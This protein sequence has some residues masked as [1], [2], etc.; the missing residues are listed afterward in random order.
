MDALNRPNASAHPGSGS[1]RTT[2]ATASTATTVRGL[3]RSA[4]RR[5]QPGRPW[6][7]GA[8]WD[9]EGVNFA[10]F[11]GAATQVELC[12]FDESGMHE[13][14]RLP[15]PARDQDIW[16][17]Y[18]PKAGPG[19]V[20]GFRADGPWRPER[21]HWYNPAK[22][23]LDPYA[24]DI[25]GQFVW[26]PEQFAADREHPRH[27]DGRDNAAF[28]LKARVIDDAFDWG[29]DRPPQ[30]AQADTVIY[31]LHVRGFTRRLTDL[32]E[33]L[34]GTFAGLAH[35]AALAHL[36]RLGVT[37]LSLM[38]VHYAIDEQRLVQMGLH[39][40]WGYNSIGFFC[41]DPAL[42]DHRAPERTRDEF[43]QMVRTLH[44]EGIEVL[45]DVVFNHTAES[46]AIGPVISLRGLD[47]AAWYRLQEDHPGAYENWT[48]CGNTLDIRQPQALRL[49]LDS[50]RHWVTDMHV[51]GFR[52]DLAPVLGR[53]NP[54]F[55]RQHPFFQALAQDPVLCRVK[56]V[57]EPWDLGPDGYQLG[58]F[59]NGW[60]EWND[61][62]RDTL[63]AF[64]LG[65]HRAPE[66]PHAAATRAEFAMRLCGS[67]DLFQPRG[68]K[69]AESVNFIAAHDGFTLRDLLSYQQ[70]H[71]EANGEDNRDGH[72]HNLSWHCGAEGKTDDP[73]V[74]QRRAR[75]QRAL[76]ACTLLAQGTPMLCAGDEFGRTQGGNNNAYCQDNA[77]SWLDWAGADAELLAFCEHVLALR[78]RL[79][80][81]A[82][83]WYSGLPDDRGL[84][85]LTWL[86]ADGAPLHG[87]AWH[88]PGQLTLACLI[89]RPGR[90][91]APLLL[92]FNAAQT[93]QRF[94][95]P[96]GVWR[97]VL[98]SVAAR[99]HSH[100]HGQ[101]DGA[102]IELSAH[103]LQL[104]A[105]AGA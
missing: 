35:P 57:A 33:P 60:L 96:S 76:L 82:A 41:P 85:D 81:F 32:P 30:V 80:P 45:L 28:A 46:D 2:S 31:E 103:S 5:L 37:S 43:R 74:L 71:N 50:L 66:S 58:G 77:T 40:Y 8:H 92:L 54:G 39:N 102:S 94:V 18:L 89:G 49:V 17:G 64:W 105:A 19:L 51:D 100:W 22:L 21:G 90:A 69:P 104:L 97:C 9:G 1:A 27:R 67:S 34:R 79:Q 75:L 93:P 56:L 83:D 20:Y 38:P 59:P 25:V 23:L 26:H 70:R 98:D 73:Q 10:V 99:G 84:P 61:R 13:Q 88:D 53:G 11:A 48:G 6:P 24:R 87:D 44:A 15:L 95:L 68:R 47:N 91:R 55:S 16:H 62:F 4:A 29:D 52:F 3:A 36:K 86:Q 72:G 12:L 65:G 78:H 42:A 63:R 14:C 101:G 7:M